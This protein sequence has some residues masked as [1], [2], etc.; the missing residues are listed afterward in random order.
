MI[1]ILRRLLK[2]QLSIGNPLSGC[3]NQ[4]MAAVFQRLI[5][6]VGYRIQKSAEFERQ[7]I[8]PQLRLGDSD[9]ESRAFCSLFMR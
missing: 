2:L 3:Q 5:Q 9:S 1:Q 8:Q 6:A 4:S 7:R